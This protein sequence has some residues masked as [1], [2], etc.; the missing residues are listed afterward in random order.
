MSE[1]TKILG[2]S[3]IVILTMIGFVVGFV[4]LLANATCTSRSSIMGLQSSW[5]ILQD[6]MVQVDGKWMPLDSYKVIR[7]RPN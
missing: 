4:A 3:L 5:G 1:E 6:C 7:I 2:I